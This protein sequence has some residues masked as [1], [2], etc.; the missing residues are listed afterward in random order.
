[1]NAMAW[2]R[3]ETRPAA[4]LVAAVALGLGLIIIRFLPPL[5]SAAMGS[6]GPITQAVAMTV[7]LF[8]P[9]IAAAAIWSAVTNVSVKALGAAPGRMAVAGAAFGIGG[10]L[11]CVLYA[12]VAN[13][14]VHTPG[15]PDIGLLLLM[16][17]LTLLQCVVEEVYFRGWIQPVLTRA[18]GPVAAIAATSLAF[19]ALHFAAEVAQTPLSLLNVA[20]AGLLFGLLAWRTGGLMA[21]MVAHCAWN[22][23]ESLGLGLFPNPG[24]DPTALVDLDLT[25]S[26]LWGGSA[27]GLNASLAVTFVLLAFCVPLAL[28]K[29]SLP[30]PATV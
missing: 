24:V 11:I 10:V 4:A 9:M 26:A 20:L 29:S 30:K 16:T 22:W 8:G 15:T 27:E 19:A 5:L 13:T 18:F 7:G 2:V 3:G 21:P 12:A 1:M 17:P 23:T 28:W 6:L 25:G 14:L